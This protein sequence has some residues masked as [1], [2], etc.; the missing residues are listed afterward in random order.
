MPNYHLILHYSAPRSVC[1][2][3]NI[4]FSYV[5]GSFYL[6]LRFL[7]AEISP[8]QDF[9]AQWQ[10]F[11]C[12][13]QLAFLFLRHLTP[14]SLRLNCRRFPVFQSFRQKMH[15]LLHVRVP[16]ITYFLV[17]SASARRFSCRSC[18]AF[19]FLRQSIT[20]FHDHIDNGI[21]CYTIEFVILVFI[22]GEK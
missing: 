14:Q 12:R 8:F 6:C 17:S 7:C 4:L 1:N 9:G 21:N 11:L 19:L 3:Q 15:W 18:F 20:Q 13:K 22:R 10:L 2:C 16:K 5:L